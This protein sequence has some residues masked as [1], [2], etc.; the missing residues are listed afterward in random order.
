MLVGADDDQRAAGQ[1][2]QYGGVGDRKHRRAVQQ[3]YVVGGRQVLQ[4]FGHGR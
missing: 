2:A 4:Q 3:D 1:F